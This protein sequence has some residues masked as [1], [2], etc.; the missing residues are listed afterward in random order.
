MNSKCLAL[1]LIF[2]INGS[3]IANANPV[4]NVKPIK[5]SDQNN[6]NGDM[7]FEKPISNSKTLSTNNR[8]KLW[9]NGV[10]PYVIGSEFGK[11]S[12]SLIE[13]SMQMIETK[14]NGCLK[15]RPK[16]SSDRNWLQINSQ[17][18]C[19]SF[20]GKN[21]E[22]GMQPV[23]LALN[24]CMY[25]GTIVHELLHAAG[26]WHEQSR[27]DRDQHLIVNLD[28]VE[29]P[30]RYNF[31][32]EYNS[33]T[34]GL[35]YDTESIMQYENTAFSMNRKPTMIARNGRPLIAA[36][37]KTDAQI[38]TEN[39]IKAI[40]VFYSCGASPVPSTPKPTVPP[41]V[42]TPTKPGPPG[43]QKINFTILNR[44]AKTIKLFQSDANLDTLYANITPGAS[45][46][47]YGY[48]GDRW[49]LRNDQ[50]GVLKAF[51][52]GMNEFA[53]DDTVFAVMMS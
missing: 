1:C 2:F 53:K 19:W 27:P 48:A 11:N 35:P 44:S 52:L 41:V 18:G 15:Y 17:D 14:S 29:K 4:D 8:A 42:T 10:I 13:Q 23:S 6:F 33:Q 32:I 9:P 43:R 20:V 49:T 46:V 22:A 21:E 28:N 16:Q 5:L 50:N 40:K 25:K 45:S 26:F 30:M 36:Y 51:T 47:Q 34:F 12:V 24:G 31:D 38:L 3:L 7:K 39:D 37:D